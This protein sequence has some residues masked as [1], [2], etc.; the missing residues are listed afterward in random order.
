MP[1]LMYKNDHTK[2]VKQKGKGNNSKVLDLMVDMR[3]N[4]YCFKEIAFILKK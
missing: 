2:L 4:K 3:S 1:Q